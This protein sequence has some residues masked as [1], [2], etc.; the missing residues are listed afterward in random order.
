MS[1]RLGASP[2]CITQSLSTKYEVP[3]TKYQVLSTKTTQLDTTQL[4]A[5]NTNNILN[6]FDAIVSKIPNSILSS[7]V[8]TR[9][10]VEYPTDRV[11]NFFHRKPL[12]SFP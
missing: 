4:N 1:S 9:P 8:A 3:S 7:L 6:P 5:N 10:N 2:G 11:S 12:S